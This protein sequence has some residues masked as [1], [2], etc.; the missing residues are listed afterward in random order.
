LGDEATEDFYF[1]PDGFGTRVVTLASTR[2]EDYAFSE[3]IVLLPQKAF[4]LEFLPTPKVDMLF[5]D[6]ERK[7]VTF[8]LEPAMYGP[9]AI[10]V[11]ADK[12]VGAG[13]HSVEAIVEQGFGI[14][15]ERRSRPSWLT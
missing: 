4:P 7:R 12:D 8:P 15:G 13:Q 14:S 2:G 9:L 6:G 3:F 11:P 5:L 1:Y 10:K